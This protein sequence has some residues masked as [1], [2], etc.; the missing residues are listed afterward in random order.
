MTEA[1][2][3]TDDLMRRLLAQRT[4]AERL[5]MC[6]RMYST[7]RALVL[8]GLLSDGEQQASAEMRRRFFLR[9]YGNEFTQSQSE[10]ILKAIFR[11]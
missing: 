6:A 7:A 4:P 5:Q 1:N 8:A 9:F 3:A 11:T 2:I 10:A